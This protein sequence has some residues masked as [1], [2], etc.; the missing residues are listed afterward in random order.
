M[1]MSKSQPT[2]LRPNAPEFKPQTTRYIMSQPDVDQMTNTATVC[3]R[4]RKETLET[5]MV[6]SKT[7]KCN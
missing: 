6:R 3:R 7:E 5:K 4:G 2:G 1:E